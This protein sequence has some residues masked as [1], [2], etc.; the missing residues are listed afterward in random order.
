[1]SRRPFRMPTPEAPILY[2][3]SGG[4][5][6]PHGSGRFSASQIEQ[7]RRTVMGKTL[8]VMLK[9][10]GGGRGLG[11]VAAHLSYINQR[12]KVDL[13]TDTDKMCLRAAISDL[14]LTYP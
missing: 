1:V 8:E 6:G 3:F 2:L 5:P 9:V 12:G 11:A 10:T 13:E 4:R 7:I 14:T